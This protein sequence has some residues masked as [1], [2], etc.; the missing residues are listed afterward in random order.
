MS[1]QKHENEHI[2]NIIRRKLTKTE[3][4]IIAAEWSE[5]C[6]YKSSKKHL[7]MLPT[8][9]PNVIVEHGYD[10][11]RDL[12]DLATNVNLRVIDS[13]IDYQKIPRCL[14]LGT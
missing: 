3:L 2:K 1:L 5:H 14:V 7:K 13:I 11:H 6:S 9:G 8:T 4:Q 12:V 10:Q